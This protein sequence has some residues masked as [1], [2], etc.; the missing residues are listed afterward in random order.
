MPLSAALLQ[1]LLC[2]FGVP[3][4]SWG[5][6]EAKSVD[7]FLQEIL[8]GESYL[9]V[10]DRG[11]ARVVA[12]VKMFISD[13]LCPQRGYLLEWGQ[14]L[15]NGKYRE[16]KQ[17]P[18]GKI[19]RGESPEEAIVREAREELGIRRCEYELSS[20]PVFRE[21]RQSASYPGFVCLYIVHGFNMILLPES[22]CRYKDQFTI[23]EENGTKQVFRWEKE[24]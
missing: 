10:D 22:N 14:Y 11:I 4:E 19:K 23:T 9:R 16:R 2:E 24:I 1:K 5:R 8:Q 18:S 12:I 21:N 20:L 6:G 3:T 13:G 17:N 7:D 15:P